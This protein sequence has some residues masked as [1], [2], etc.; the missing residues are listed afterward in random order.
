MLHAG[1]PGGQHTQLTHLNYYFRQLLQ[2]WSSLCR[3]CCAPAQDAVSVMC[4]EDAGIIAS[5]THLG[6]CVIGR[7][8]DSTSMTLVVTLRGGSSW[9]NVAKEMWEYRLVMARRTFLTTYSRKQHGQQAREAPMGEMEQC[10]TLWLD[11][12]SVR[13]KLFLRSKSLFKNA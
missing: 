4:L 10:S 9:K 3:P 12:T 6:A 11:G 1:A 7:D 8:V 2:W 13:P 5:A